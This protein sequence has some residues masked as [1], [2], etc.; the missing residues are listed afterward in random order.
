[1]KTKKVKENDGKQKRIKFKTNDVSKG[2]RDV[3]FS[4]LFADACLQNARLLLFKKSS[5]NGI[6]ID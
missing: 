3:F 4:F 2:E 5:P 1:M 6:G